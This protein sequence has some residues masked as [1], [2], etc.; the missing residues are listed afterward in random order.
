MP[1]INRRNFNEEK[2]IF[3]FA[4][5]NVTTKNVAVTNEF[6]SPDAEGLKLVNAGM[7]V[8]DVA[9][10]IR[11][12]P[13]L[14]L[15]AATGTGS[16]FVVGTPVVPFVAGDVLYVVEPQATVTIGGTVAEDDV[17]TITIN[18]IPVTATAATTTLADL[19]ALAAANINSNTQ[20][21]DLVKAIVSGGVIYLYAIDGVSTYS[22]AVAETSSAVTIAVGGSATQFAYGTAIGT[23]ASVSVATNTITLE[24]NASAVVPIGAHLGVRVNSVLGL[25]NHQREFNYE[26]TQNFGLFTE[27]NGVKENLLPYVDG[28]LKRRFSKLTFAAKA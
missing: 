2:Q 26:T 8:A 5:G 4:E 16:K 28:D 11:F 18:G 3:W 13:R 21:K 17:V 1:F 19:V 15:T 7:F 14:T 12:L 27:S 24:A 22:I 9:G 10:D 6:L 20:V 25:D 23:V